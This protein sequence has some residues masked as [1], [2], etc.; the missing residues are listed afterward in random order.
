MTN[1]NNMIYASYFTD[2]VCDTIRTNVTPFGVAWKAYSTF[3]RDFQPINSTN[4]ILI[5][6]E[7]RFVFDEIKSTIQL[8]KHAFHTFLSTIGV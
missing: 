2:E 1:S 3:H 8:P 4:G 7:F 5:M 6:K